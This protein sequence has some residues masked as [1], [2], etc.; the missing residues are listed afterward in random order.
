ML[1]KAEKKP[2]TLAKCR[3]TPNLQ[4]GVYEIHMNNYNSLLP[5]CQATL[6]KL[7]IKKSYNKKIIAWAKANNKEKI[8]QNIENCATQVGITSIDGKA[9]I[10]RADFC[11]ERICSVCAWRRQARF[12]S[13]TNPILNL[14]DKDYDFLFVTLTM[15][16]VP[17]DKLSGAVDLILSAY[18][19]FRHIRQIRR[20]FCGIIRALELTF[21]ADRKDFHPHLHLLVAVRKDYFYSQDYITQRMLAEIWQGC[22]D[23]DY[24]P[25]V[26]IRKCDTVEENP[27]GV[28]EVLKYSLKPSYDDL[29]LKAFAVILKGR[30]LI[31]FSGVFAEMRKKLRLSDFENVLTDEIQGKTKLQYTLFEFD[32]TGGYYNYLKTM[33]VKNINGRWADF[34]KE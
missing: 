31:S 10:I 2:Y 23:V 15:R 28:L 26:D 17:Y 21:N 25:S 4:I 24:I 20:S 9:H 7:A 1:L 6:R 32:C 16:N 5:E 14:L 3:L 27:Q 12:I 29:A 8:A 13:Q 34:A 30:R 11:R 33:E 22:L 19:K 18:A